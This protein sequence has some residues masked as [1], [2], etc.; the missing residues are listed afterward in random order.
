MSR[1]F[2]S[3]GVAIHYVEAGAGPPVVLVHS[4]AGD[5]RSQWVQTGVLDALA[6]DYRAIAFDHR[7]HGESGKPH[8]PGAYGVRMTWD[9]ARLMDHLAIGRAHIVGYSM[10]AHLVAQLL[11]LAPRR[12]LS[13]T[14]GG[15][16]GRRHWGDAEERQVE[17]E[18]GEMERGSLRAQVLRLWP[19]GKPPPR[20]EVIARSSALFLRGKDC[21]A[22]AASR[23]SNREQVFA[24]EDLSGIDAPVLGIVGSE[25]PYLASYD[26]LRAVLPRIERVVIEGADHAGA[27][28][29]KEFVEALLGFLKKTGV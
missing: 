21:L 7:G 1:T 4:Y 29:R 16:T 23:R 2:D 22:L 13:A 28:G 5:L 26:E 15:G 17:I 6:R 11:T 24:T 14:L 18:A 25:D 19:E 10:G 20:D 12:F 9:I 8:D 27:A 3:D